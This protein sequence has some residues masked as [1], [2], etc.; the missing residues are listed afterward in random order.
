MSENSKKFN[1]FQFCN[2]TFHL[3][4]PSWPDT[5]MIRFTFSHFS[6]F[7][8]GRYHTKYLVIVLVFIIDNPSCQTNHLRS[9]RK[10]SWNLGFYIYNSFYYKLGIWVKNERYLLEKLF[11]SMKHR[12]H[13]LPLFV[14]NLS[15]NYCWF[16][17]TTLPASNGLM[18]YWLV[19]RKY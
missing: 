10:L 18:E 11:S 17:L 9:R 19:L 2:I 13:L 12:Q 4:C 6:S 16:Q 1:K 7:Y 3:K 5:H 8:Q 14:H 15:Y